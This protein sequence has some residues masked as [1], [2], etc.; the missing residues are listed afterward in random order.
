MNRR[1]FIKGLLAVAVYSVV[2]VN[3]VQ[4]GDWVID[5]VN[6]HI[7]YVGTSGKAYHV[8]ELHRWLMSQWENRIEFGILDT[9]EVYEL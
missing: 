9:E 2:P 8:V 5:V 3:P 7:K 1:E 4:R 6:K